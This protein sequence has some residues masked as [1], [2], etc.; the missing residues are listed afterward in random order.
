MKF[1]RWTETGIEL[2]EGKPGPLPHGWVRLRVVANGICG[3]DLH[4]YRRELPPLPGSVPGHEI[5]GVPLEGPGDLAEA[6]YAVEPQTWCGQCDPCISGDHHLCGEK[7]IFGIQAPGGLAEWVD[8]P[9]LA[10]HA[11]DRSVPSLVASLCE[12]FSVSVRAINLARLESSSRVLVLGAGSIGLLVGLLARDRAQ[13]VAITARHPQ[14]KKAASELGLEVLDENSAMG[15]ALNYGPDVII[16]TVGGRADTMAEAVMLC[17]AGGRI[18]MLGVFAGDRPLNLLL[19]MIKE[20]TLVGSNTYG[21]TRRG[22]EFGSGVELLPR[23][24]T[25]LAPLLTHQFPLSELEQAFQCAGDK[26]SGAIKVSVLPGK[27]P[28]N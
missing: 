26:S 15:W 10:L 7:R 24:A 3:S 2:A 19:L 4:M 12:P 18:V 22:S 6:L 14:Q 28:G 5:V 8:L 27:P 20:L 11:V 17:R 23:Y 1:A 16:E 21:T 13:R 25:E 9:R